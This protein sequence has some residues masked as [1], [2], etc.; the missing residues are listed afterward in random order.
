MISAALKSCSMMSPPQ[1]DPDLELPS[2]STHRAG[3]ET[4]SGNKLVPQPHSP[5]S[6]N[7]PAPP[8]SLSQVASEVHDKDVTLGDEEAAFQE[9]ENQNGGALAR[10]QTLSP[11]TGS[12]QRSQPS[13]QDLAIEISRT[14]PAPIPRT[15]S[16]PET[17]QEDIGDFSNAS[18][19]PV[20]EVDFM[21]SNPHI[22]EVIDL[23][24]DGLYDQSFATKEQAVK[25][26]LDDA[27][28]LAEPDTTPKQPH[29]ENLLGN[30]SLDPMDLDET[31]ED[32][33]ALPELEGSDDVWQINA[34]DRA[35]ETEDAM[36][37]IRNAVH[38][39]RS[40]FLMDL[41][42]STKRASANDDFEN[43]GLS[44]MDSEAED[45]VAV[46]EFEEMSEEYLRKQKA[47][48]LEV[49]DE[50]EFNRANQVEFERKRRSARNNARPASPQQDDQS[51]FFPDDGRKSPS[52]APE[53]ADQGLQ[54]VLD[55]ESQGPME[56]SPA[57]KGSRKGRGRRQSSKTYASG[58]IRKTTGKPSGPKKV[59][60]DGKK[61]MLNS[62]NVGSL[63]NN[64]LIAIAQ[65]NQKRENQ[66][67]FTS[68]D[69][70]KALSELISSMPKEQQK[71]HGVDKRELER[72]SKKFAGKGAMRSDGAGRWKLKGMKSSLHHYQ[73]LGA[74]FMRDLE[75]VSWDTD[76]RQ[77][78][79][80]N[81]RGRASHLVDLSVMTWVLVRLSWLS[82]TSSTGDL[83]R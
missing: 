4:S 5:K 55:E 31:L 72:A 22:Y 73:L 7:I 60:K 70:R 40:A 8:K 27:M 6:K 69:K 54:Q 79:L 43:A 52:P 20:E 34:E 44:D 36:V 29:T 80:T 13:L 11:A 50:I 1:H 24:D 82:V 19:A 53:A 81:D 63:F 49:G 2:E 18:I 64:D 12:S 15:R 17:I 41:P 26:E 83:N 58:G 76:L 21:E 51:M 28:V 35:E 67:T 42:L 30:A 61:L 33:S 71:L 56:A 57:G 77:Q 38:N 23:T 74:A 59:G 3:S 47:G 16:S 32:P 78:M 14:D 39:S 48:K 37:M 45:A 46:A 25:Q 65:E 10:P 66:P 68:K 75:E 62:V 9:M